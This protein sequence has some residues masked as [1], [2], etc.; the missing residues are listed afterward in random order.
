MRCLGESAVKLCQQR[1]S[2]PLM[3]LRR[4]DIDPMQ[5][6]LG[7]LVVEEAD[8]AP[9]PLGDEKMRI[10]G[11]ARLTVER[12]ASRRVVEIHDVCVCC[13]R[14]CR[15]VPGGEEAGELAP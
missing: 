9:A 5:L 11:A 8:N 2:D 10:C 7:S 3:L 14:T 4:I 6:G 12:S 1:A 13:L 15:S